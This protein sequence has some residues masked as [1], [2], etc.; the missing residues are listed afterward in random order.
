MFTQNAITILSQKNESVTA[1]GN[2]LHAILFHLEADKEWQ[3][4]YLKAFQ[5]YLGFFVTALYLN[6]AAE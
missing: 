2:M 3:H 4:F 6:M 5:K 1:T